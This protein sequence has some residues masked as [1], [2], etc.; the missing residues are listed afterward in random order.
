MYIRDSL[1]IALLVILVGGFASAFNI[2]FV[3]HIPDISG[4]WWADDHS[5]IFEAISDISDIYHFNQSGAKIT[6]VYE[7]YNP[8]TSQFDRFKFEAKLDGNT[9]DFITPVA[10]GGR[11]HHKFIFSKDGKTADYYGNEIGTPESSFPISFIKVKA[12]R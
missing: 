12:N 10:F 2:P 9:L 4:T 5:T 3:T 7:S 8:I 6:G 1:A 11:L